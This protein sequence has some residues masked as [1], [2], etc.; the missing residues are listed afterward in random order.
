M[1]SQQPAPGWYP[2]PSGG[3]AQRYW[4]GQQ[5]QAAGASQPS[6]AVAP[7]GG[8]AP[9]GAVNYGVDAYGRPLSDKSK[10][11][12]GLLQLFIGTLGIGRFYLG[13]STIGVLQ[14]VTL[15]GCGFWSLIDAIMILMG[16]VPDA[17]GR[18]LRD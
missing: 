15:G 13:Y 8:A 4:D 5:W 1:T 14:L 6:A 18:T 7:Y 11:V 3:P 10:L 17:Q 9:Y 2:D 12:A 16:N